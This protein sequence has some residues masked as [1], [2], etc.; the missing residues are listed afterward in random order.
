MF[1]SLHIAS[2][3]GVASPPSTRDIIRYMRGRPLDFAPGTRYVY[4]NF[5]YAVL[6]RIIEKI[7]GVTYEQ[8]VRTNV[9]TPVGITDMKI[10]QTLIAGKQQ[11]EVTYYMEP[12]AALAH[13]VF[14]T[15]PGSLPWPYGGFSLEAM[16]SHGGWL[17][18]AIDLLKFWNGI[19]GRRG[20]AL[21]TS[22]SL[23]LLT[24]RP[25]IPDW[26]ATSYW[27]GLGFLIR[28]SGGDANWWH[29][30]SLPGTRTWAVRT[31]NGYAWA[32]LFN[33]RRSDSTLDSQFANELDNGLWNAAAAVSNWPTIDLFPAYTPSTSLPHVGSFAQ[34]ASG[35]GWKTSMTVMNLTAGTVNA[36]INFY[37]ED[38]S[39][40]LL[41]LTLSQS[42]STT[43]ASSQTFSLGP[44]ESYVIQTE[45]AG[46]A[47]KVGWA[48]VQ[49]SGNLAGYSIFRYRSS[50]LPD[51]EGTAALDIGSPTSIVLPY[52]NSVGFHTGMALANLGITTNNITARLLDI[53]GSL[54]SSQQI[55]LGP[56]GHM[57][58]FI[59]Q[60]FPAAAN[61]LGILQ[62]Q[63][64]A[65]LTVVGLRFSPTGTFTSVPVSH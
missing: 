16:D 6:G 26:A 32:A 12:G 43:T 3:V 2:V 9:F 53:R 15:S 54:L 5:G 49:A 56:Q 59:D 36:Q 51:S 39:P 13:S 35:G 17:A 31:Y 24:A 58:F 64:S 20:N 14:A 23:G 44:N 60:Q 63:S 42:G 18:S 11:G 29:D 61:Q 7:T 52:D 21:L 47:V 38:G 30:G 41:P 65:G 46:T 62:L 40:M 33:E 4:S 27:Y 50:G 22:S 25:A 45:A 10:G 19:D 1:D 34:V 57:S 8:Y 55:T 37:S 28:P 48:D